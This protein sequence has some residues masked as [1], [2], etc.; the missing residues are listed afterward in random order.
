MKKLIELLVRKFRTFLT[1]KKRRKEIIPLYGMESFE[2][3]IILK[4]KNMISFS[5]FINNYQKCIDFTDNFK[6]EFILVNIHKINFR[7]KIGVYTLTK[8]IPDTILQ[9]Y[10]LKQSLLLTKEEIASII[11]CMFEDYYDYLEYYNYKNWLV[12]YYINTDG[13]IEAV[14]ID[15]IFY[16]YPTLFNGGWK[17][18]I[19]SVTLKN[20]KSI[21]SEYWGKNTKIIIKTATEK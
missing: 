17:F 19:N 20:Y 15:I 3:R 9:E 8:K 11:V 18:I 7:M 12:G 1:T 21:F 13:D 10:F 14:Y 16:S 6:K 2:K 4:K 5:N